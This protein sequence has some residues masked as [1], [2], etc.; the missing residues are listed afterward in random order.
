MIVMMVVMVVTAMAVMEAKMMTMMMVVV[1]MA[2]MEVMM[3]TA[4]PLFH[5]RTSPSRAVDRAEPLH[6]AQA[7]ESEKLSRFKLCS[8][9][10]APY[11]SVVSSA[12]VVS[13]SFLLVCLFQD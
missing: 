6:F 10:L 3:M 13:H 11:L 1:A 12:A 8:S 4:T 7:R 9:M 2:V 5:T